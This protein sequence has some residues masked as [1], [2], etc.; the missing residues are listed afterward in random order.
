MTNIVDLLAALCAHLP[1]A[2]LRYAATDVEAS[3]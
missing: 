1:F 2:A 3:A